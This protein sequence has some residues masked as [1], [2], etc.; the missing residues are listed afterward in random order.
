MSSDSQT[1]DE[2]I[3]QRGIFIFFILLFVWFV[4][5]F[6]LGFVLF[7]LH[8]ANYKSNHICSQIV[9]YVNLIVMVCGL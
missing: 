2:N 3:Q 4:L 6:V 5:L 9:R 8:F 7:L 1:A